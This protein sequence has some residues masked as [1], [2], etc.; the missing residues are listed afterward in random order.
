MP[1]CFERD[2]VRRCDCSV[3]FAFVTDA[4]CVDVPAL[5]KPVTTDL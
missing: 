2:P 3:H 5:D 1:A 4:R